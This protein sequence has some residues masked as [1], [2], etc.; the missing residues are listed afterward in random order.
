MADK[1]Q[2]QLEILHEIT[3]S[4]DTHSSKQD[5]IEKAVTKFI[6]TSLDAGIAAHDVWQSLNEIYSKKLLL[7]ND[8]FRWC[9]DEI[10][11]QNKIRNPQATSPIRDG[12]QQLN[13]IFFDKVIVQNSLVACHM[14]AKHRPDTVTKDVSFCHSICEVSISKNIPVVPKKKKPNNIR[15]LELQAEFDTITSTS[16][17]SSEPLAHKATIDKREQIPI[18]TEP[19]VSAPA[20]VES[21]ALPLHRYLIAKQERDFESHSIYYIAFSSH[22]DLSQWKDNHSS[23]EEGLQI[24]LL[25]TVL[26]NCIIIAEYACAGFQKQKEQLPFQFILERLWE[27]DSVVLTGKLTCFKESFLPSDLFFL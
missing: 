16:E 12:K 20:F 23:F 5:I 17:N 14:L 13:E 7:D 2:K 22:E 6:C 18:E 15:M 21:A 1:L 4:Q 10:E 26:S 9:M 11:K 27:G 8:T 19:A 24:Y 3:D 25:Q